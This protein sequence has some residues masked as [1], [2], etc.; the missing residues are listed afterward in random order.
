[1]RKHYDKYLDKV[2]GGIFARFGQKWNME[3]AG[4]IKDVYSG[5]MDAPGVTGMKVDVEDLMSAVLQSDADEES[6]KVAVEF[7]ESQYTHCKNEMIEKLLKIFV[8]EK[9]GNGEWEVFRL[10]CKDF[11]GGTGFCYKQEVDLDILSCVAVHRVGSESLIAMAPC[12]LYND[13]M[14]RRQV[15]LFFAFSQCLFLK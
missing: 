10:E 7:S 4:V 5:W 12:D 1:M 11:T 6:Y 2:R 3:V 8:A 15:P 9:F 13:Q 14:F